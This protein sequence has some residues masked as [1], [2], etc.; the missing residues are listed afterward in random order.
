MKDTK[1][2]ILDAALSVFSEKGY[3]SATTL[4]ISKRAGV[5]EMTLFRHFQTK[6]NLFLVTVK[7]A[8]GES[9]VEDVEVDVNIEP[10]EFIMEL[11]HEKLTM[12]SQHVTLIKMLI[13]ETLSHTLPEEL[14]FTKVISKQVT[15][16]ISH[17]VCHHDLAIDPIF[18]A[19]LVVGLLLR[20]AIMEDKSVYHRLNASDQ[21]KY[22]K[23]YI[24]ILNI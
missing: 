16:K 14:E 8:V 5:S 4:E 12:I 13:R 6:N 3:V 18:L 23:N 15:K 20:H 7:Q 11:L 9:L 19:Q 24:N 21:K 17:Y 2:L 22:L 10:E 1:D